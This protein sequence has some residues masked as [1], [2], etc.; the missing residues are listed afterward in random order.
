MAE[1]KEKKETMAK[2]PVVVVLGHIDHGK[3]S[4]LE[5]IRDL[6]ITE[7]E[8]GGMTQHSGADE[9]VQEGKKITFIDTPGHEAF[10]AMRSRGAKVA[11]IA[12]LVVAADEG[13]KPQ[14]KEAIEHIK[15]A[16]IPLIVAINKMDKPGADP[17]KVKKELSN[18]DVLVEEMG[19]KV[20]CVE[21]SAKEKTG[22][23]DILNLI[24]LVA[25][26]EELRADAQAEARG[27]IIESRSDPSRGPASTLI[28]NQGILKVGDVI[29]TSSTCGKI[30]R[31]ED[32]QGNELEVAQVSQPVVVLGFR[33]VPGIGETFKT[34]KNIQEAEAAIRKSSVAENGA[35]PLDEDEQ[36]KVLNLILK[37]DVLGSVE[38]IE[39]VLKTLPQDKVLLRILKRGVGEVSLSDIQL[40]KSSGAVILGFRVKIGPRMLELARKERVR[41][42]TFDLIYDLVEGV[43]TIM[44]RS[45]SPQKVRVE[46][47][48][49][50]VLVVFKTEGKRQ[51]VGGR[52]IEGEFSKGVRVEVLRNDEVKGAGRVISIQRNKRDIAKARK[53]DEV[54]ILY[55]GD[56]RIEEK[57]VLLMFT[58]ETKAGQL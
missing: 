32:F 10:S 38:P 5:A 34:F 21:V 15:K 42:L 39:E 55:E 40:A 9:V 18:Q 30:K 58:E 16:G 41:V 33:N 31:M 35:P 28:L 56:T 6:K 36:R 20:P 19:G 8:T 48:K 49:M 54:G 7:K 1:D 3:S 12:I 44:T 25:E 43:R 57:D 13:V 17:R 11:D 27:S 46:L 37:V 4:L 52:V 24:L 22:I 14:T 50:N 23:D 53:G 51:I 47:G 29:G 2:P 26:M 45:L